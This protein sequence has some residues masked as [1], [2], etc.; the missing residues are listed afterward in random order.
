MADFQTFHLKCKG[1]GSNYEKPYLQ[2][3]SPRLPK[4]VAIESSVLILGKSA[5]SLCCDDIKYWSV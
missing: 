4:F 5:I 3:C 1:C 2:V